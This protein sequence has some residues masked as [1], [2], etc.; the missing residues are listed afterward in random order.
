MDRWGFFAPKFK[1]HAM[2]LKFL[3]IS[4]FIFTLSFAQN[5]GTITGTVTDKDLNNETLPFA[6]VAIK[7]TNI[8][9]NTDEN[10]QYSLKVPAGSHILVFGFLGYE[11]IEM[12]ITITAGETKTINQA[13]GSTSVQL[14]DVVIEKTVNREKESALLLEQKNAV[15]ITQSIGAQEMSRKGVS[16]AESALTKVSGISKQQGETNVFVRGLGDRYNS[17][18][19]N[20]LPLPS[21]KPSTKNMSLDFF[22]SDVIKNIGV[23]K[24]FGAELYGDVSGANINIISKEFVGD[25]YIEIGVA[26]GIN[27]QTVNKD[28]FTIDGGTFTGFTDND[29]PVNNLNEYTFENSLD[30]NM[31]STQLN[32]SLGVSGGKRFQIGDNN[33]SM[34]LTASFSNGYLYREGVVRQTGNEGALIQD[35]DFE[36][37]TYNVSQIAMGS[38]K[39][40]YSTYNTLSFNTLYVHD[41]V[42]DL[43]NYF[44][45]NGADGQTTDLAYLRRQ[46]VNNN[47]IFVNQLLSEMQLSEKINLDMGVTYNIIRS[48]EPDRRSNE[49]LF[50]DG[51][52]RPNSDSAGNHQRYFDE[53]KENELAGRAVFSYS[54]MNE[55]ESKVSFGLNARHSIRE[56]DATIFTHR[57]F[58]SSQSI[59]IN[60]FDGLFNQQSLDNGLFSLQTERASTQNNPFAFDPFWYDGL[61]NIYAG[62]AIFNHS[63]T[64]DLILSAGVR[65]ENVYQRVDY[66]TNIATNATFGDAIIDEDY[67]LPS[68]NLKYSLNEKNILR[69]AGSMSYTLPQFIEVAPFKYQDVSF[70]VQGNNQLV[71]A[72]TYNI[73]LKYEFYPSGDELI[74]VTAFYKNIDNPINRSEIPVGGNTLTFFNT[75]STATVAGI[76]LETKVNL[77]KIESTETGKETLFSGGLNISYLHTR[78]KLEASLPQFTKDEDELQGASPVLANADLTFFKEGE[79]YDISTSVVFNYFSDRIYSIGTRG[80]ENIIETGIPTL[81]FIAKSSLGEHFGLSLKAQNLLNPDFQLIREGGAIAPETTLATYKRGVNLSLGLSYKF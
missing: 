81:D 74:A 63:F 62:Y 16:D 1:Q 32:S 35:M 60:N 79:N 6:S 66:N 42:Q 50:R 20:G 11:T 61:R 15:T 28:F 13:M 5:T 4:L 48:S 9:T 65:Y 36:R 33:L 39:Y 51:T 46:Q 26:S 72:E 77:Y 10:G 53:M 78:Q 37:Y 30:P 2:K 54:F 44:G 68:L 40:R 67:I 22:S 58:N 19:L 57:F 29:V 18:T 12:P 75:G 59:D 76:E 8:G 7:G 31:Q 47:N 17:T 43:G 27:T 69:L 3:F 56:F 24:T 70:S 49:L 34:F 38:F 14:E 55:Q 73:D 45:F 23:N 80:Y 41:N 21:E 52:Y 71:P 25:D 64:P